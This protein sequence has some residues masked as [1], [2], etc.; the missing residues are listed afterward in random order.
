MT[1]SE[2]RVAGRWHTP[3]NSHMTAIRCMQM[4]ACAVLLHPGNAFGQAPGQGGSGTQ[5]TTNTDA[6][7]GLWKAKRRFG[8]DARGR[9]VLARAANGYTAEMLGFTIPVRGANGELSFDLPNGEG[10]FRGKIQAN[11][12]LRGFWFPNAMNSPALPTAAV[13]VSLQPEGQNRWLGEVEPPEDNHTFFLHLTKQPDGSMAAL[14]RTIERDFG[15]LFG[16][17]GLVRTGNEITLVGRRGTQTRDAVIV[18][19]SFDSVQQ[20]MTITFPTRGGTYDFRREVDEHSAFYPRGKHP[21]RYRYREPP[22]LDESWPTASVDQVGIDRAGIERAVQHLID[23]SMDS[24]NAPQAHA[25][26]IARGGKLVLEEYFHGTHRDKPH[27]VRSASKSV[28]TTIIGAAMQAG[29]GLRLSTPVYQAMYGGVVPSDLE[30]RKRAMTLEHLMAMSAGYFCDDNND[31]APG[32]EN[33]M[34]EQTEEPDFSRFALKLPMASAPGEQSIYCSIQPHLALGVAGQAAGESPLYLFE[35]LIADPMAIR[36]YVWAVDRAGNPYGG[37]GMLLTGRDF[38][39]FGQLMLN[40]GT[41]RG[42]RILSAD[43]VERASS[44]LTR[45]GQRE[46]GMLW[47]PQEYTHMNRKLRG[48]AALGNGGNVVYVI[49]ELDLVIG[50]LGASYASRGWRYLTG[51]FINNLVL[52]AVQPR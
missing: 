19:G 4:L 37:G 36:N 11:G 1:C 12:A 44:P 5:A 48:Y 21:T 30:A 39:K 35:R 14:L 8:P 28:T 17:R 15:G 33:G 2:L 34:W 20:V 3:L 29:A 32:N 13:P 52:P 51:D 22:A 18:T 43:F 7:A 23:M 49:P 40:R 46:Y 42:R 50:T 6:L 41:W 27:N 10:G 26:V 24:L 45:I 38:I 25:L 31:A 16:V 9:L 47:W